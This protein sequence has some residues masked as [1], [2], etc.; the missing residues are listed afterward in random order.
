[1]LQD[2]LS[3]LVE[4]VEGD[5]HLQL[6]AKT[7]IRPLKNGVDYLGWRFVFGRNGKVLRLLKQGSKQRVRRQIKGISQRY[8]CGELDDSELNQRLA[9][10]QGHLKQGN[11]WLFGQRVGLSN[12]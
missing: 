9:S 1:V 8:A 11:A 2:C 7:E 5:L 6:N 12:R 10:F 4:L 3:R